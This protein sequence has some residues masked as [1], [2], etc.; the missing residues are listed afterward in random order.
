VE[1]RAALRGATGKVTSATVLAGLWKL[2]NETLGGL[3]PGMTF[4]KGKNATK[5]PCFSP[6][7]L[8]NQKWRTSSK[9]ICLSL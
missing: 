1:F 6:I 3:V 9:R 5:N 2:K 7:Q 8:L 4:T